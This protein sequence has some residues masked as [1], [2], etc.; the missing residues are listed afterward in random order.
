MSL[1]LKNITK[2]FGKKVILDDLSY[3]FSEKGIFAILGESGVG[4]TTLLRIIS[5]IDR[6]FIGQV[7]DG[8][9]SK[10]A[11]CFQEHRLFK[12]LTAI[13]NLTEVSFKNPGED[14]IKKARNLL[15]R[16]H[17]SEEEMELYP[18]ELSG[19]MKQRIALARALLRDAPILILD[20]PTK[21]LDAELVNTVLELIKEEGEKRLVL[22]VTHKAE[23]V[24]ALGA[25]AITLLSKIS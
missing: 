16:L 14:D 18:D 15:L 3:E 21:E 9:I 1:I 17:F 25:K 10:T 20:E 12:E 4:K 19:G 7:I 13:E 22:I 8:G 2:S 11:V 24:E 5:G 6:K 23:E